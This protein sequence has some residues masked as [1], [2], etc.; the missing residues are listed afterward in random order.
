MPR[1]EV[2]IKRSP[3][4]IKY[5]N[6]LY[7]Q[8]TPHCANHIYIDVQPVTTQYFL[9]WPHTDRHPACSAPAD[10]LPQLYSHNLLYLSSSDYTFKLTNNS[11]QAYTKTSTRL[12][13]IIN[14]WGSS[15][16]HQAY[17]KIMT[18][19]RLLLIIDTWFLVSLPLLISSLV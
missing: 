10:Q 17:L 3:N 6:P 15:H 18:D 14:I 11:R 2:P 8:I 12:L 13:V 1:G 9:V 5:Y 16:F 4:K 7:P 19:Y